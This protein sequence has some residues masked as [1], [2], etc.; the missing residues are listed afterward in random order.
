MD[1]YQGQEAKIIFISCVLSKPDTI[2]G[3]SEKRCVCIWQCVRVRLRVRVGVRVGVSVGVRVGVRVMVR[4]G[5][6]VAVLGS[7]VWPGASPVGRTRA[8]ERAMLITPP[9]HRAA[10][11]AHSHRAWLP[12]ICSVGGGATGL[13]MPAGSVDSQVG[14]WHNPKRF[15]VAITR[16]RALLVV[17]GHPLVLLEDYCW[18]EFLR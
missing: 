4:V 11:C 6:R 1:D 2:G 8:G 14:F 16:A 5:F 15:N 10:S 9:G 12:L 7:F 3:P 17:V 13:G 18:R